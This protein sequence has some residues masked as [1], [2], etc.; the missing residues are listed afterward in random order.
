MHDGNLTFFFLY[1]PVFI[2]GNYI[3]PIFYFQLMVEFT[4]SSKRERISMTFLSSSQSVRTFSVFHAFISRP[5]GYSFILK[6]LSCIIL[7]T[8]HSYILFGNSIT[9]YLGYFWSDK[10][11]WCSEKK[12]WEDIGVRKTL[13]YDDCYV[14]TRWFCLFSVSNNASIFTHTHTHTDNPSC[15]LLFFSI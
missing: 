2:Q 13:Y 12:C 14:S 4:F 1:F 10:L 7:G 9:F 6:W 11:L 8:F 15:K 3:Y 5:P